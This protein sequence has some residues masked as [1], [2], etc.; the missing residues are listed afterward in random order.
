M[1][2]DIYKY[3]SFTCYL[4]VDTLYDNTANTYNIEL[5]IGSTNSRY[6]TR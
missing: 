5:C 2:V 4:I 1:T 6:I 3:T